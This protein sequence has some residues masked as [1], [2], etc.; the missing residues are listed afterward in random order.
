M[1]KGMHHPI[2]MATSIATGIK[3]VCYHYLVCNAKQGLFYSTICRQALFIKI[4]WECHYKGEKIHFRLEVS[5]LVLFLWAW[6]EAAHCGQT[7][8][9]EHSSLLCC[10]LD[11]KKTGSKWSEQN[12][13][14]GQ[15]STFVMLYILGFSLL[16][17]VIY[18]CNAVHTRVFIATN[19]EPLPV[20]QSVTKDE[21]VLE[22]LSS[23][24]WGFVGCSVL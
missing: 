11:G 5:I 13:E 10:R 3:G 20:V 7:C 19:W 1:I 18:F 2:S 15:W 8:L 24:N 23:C 22:R 16:P 21:G 4:Q 6:G 12:I 9:V 14:W 17:T